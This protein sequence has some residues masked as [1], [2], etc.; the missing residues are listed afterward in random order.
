[1]ASL[2]AE[3]ERLP[4]GHTAGGEAVINRLSQLSEALADGDGTLAGT[5]STALER[6]AGA[7]RAVQPGIWAIA[8]QIGLAV[9]RL[10][11]E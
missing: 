9:R 1:M 3:I 6:D 11:G 7:L 2:Q 5:Y 8:R 10:A 4:A